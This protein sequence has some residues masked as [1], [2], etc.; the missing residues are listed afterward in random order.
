MTSITLGEQDRGLRRLGIASHLAPSVSRSKNSTELPTQLWKLTSMLFR[1]LLLD[2]PYL[3][4]HRQ[5]E[6]LSSPWNPWWQRNHALPWSRL[7]YWKPNESHRACFKAGIAAHRLLGSPTWRQ[8][9]SVTGPIFINVEFSSCLK[10]GKV[11]KSN[12]YPF[13]FHQTQR[14]SCLPSRSNLTA[15]WRWQLDQGGRSCLSDQLRLFCV[16]SSIVLPSLIFLWDRSFL[17]RRAWDMQCMY[18]QYICINS[19]IHVCHVS[20]DIFYALL[21]CG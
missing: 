3:R 16:F 18:M 20:C 17:K 6:F 5:L 2:P 7:K 19:D 14:L 1:C 8:V 21:L 15:P 9:S 13:P 4:S 10:G 11:I 12:I